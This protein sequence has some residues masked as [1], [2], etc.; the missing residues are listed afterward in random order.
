[1]STACAAL[2]TGT[3]TDGSFGGATVGS[4]GTLTPPTTVG[5]GTLGG[6]GAGEASGALVLRTGG[7][8]AVRPRLER[9]RTEATFSRAGIFAWPAGAKNVEPSG[10][11]NVLRLVPKAL[12]TRAAEPSSATS[13]RFAETEATLRW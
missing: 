6:S 12:P 7:L 5:I 1:M 4:G 2:A 3:F 11:L 13:V 9:P 8:T 10:A